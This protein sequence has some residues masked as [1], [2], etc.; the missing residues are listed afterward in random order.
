M[1]KQHIIDWEF[2]FIPNTERREQWDD[3]KHKITLTYDFAINDWKKPNC[4]P[5]QEFLMYDEHIHNSFVCIIF[6][7][8]EY[9]EENDDIIKEKL[10][11]E[12]QEEYDI[13]LTNI[14]SGEHF[15]NES[16]FKEE[17]ARLHEL[18]RGRFRYLLLPT[19]SE[20]FTPVYIDGEGI[21][22]RFDTFP[23]NGQPLQEKPSIY[24]MIDFW[25]KDDPKY[26]EVK[27]EYW[28]LGRDPR[29][30]KTQGIHVTLKVCGK[31]LKIEIMI[32]YHLQYEI[33]TEIIRSNIKSIHMKFLT[34]DR[35]H[36]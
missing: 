4:I 5:G 21:W 28:L 16:D 14:L 10:S 1:T 2:H 12:L 17:M 24:K 35:L 23:L 36:E 30:T 15:N 22:Y 25:Y 8:D 31:F 19:I 13:L 6:E 20:Q 3:E 7:S 33:C 34:N 32:M 18:N 11:E 29:T 26:N 27:T 9:T